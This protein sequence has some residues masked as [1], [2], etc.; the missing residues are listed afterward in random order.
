MAYLF[1]I[2]YQN[3]T[4]FHI[5]TVYCRL[6]KRTVYN[7]DMSICVCS[8]RVINITLRQSLSWYYEQSNVDTEKPQRLRTLPTIPFF[9]KI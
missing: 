7:Y 3:F 8:H 1:Y 5:E 9:M 2:G 4:R 6:F